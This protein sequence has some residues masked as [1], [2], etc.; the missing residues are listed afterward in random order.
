MASMTMRLPFDPARVAGPAPDPPP[1][2]PAQR[3]PLTV[4]Q[5]ADLI[6][7]AL[8]QRL[9]SPIRVIGQVSNLSAAHHWYFTLKDESA[10][11]SCI[12]WSSSARKFGFT[13]G[14][15][16]EVIAAGHVSH[17]PPQGRTQLYVSQ[18]TPVGAGAL[19]LRF[20]QMCRELRE[21]GYFEEGRKKPLP[22]FPRRIAVITSASGAALRDVVRTAS[23][24]CRAVGLVVLDVRVQGE[25]AAE[26]V[27]RAIAWADRHARRLDIDAVLVTRG[28]GSMEDL[29][30]F[31]ERA[32]AEAAYRCRLPLVAAIG[33]ESDT[34]VIE[35]VADR[36]ASTPTQAAMLLVPDAAELHKQVSHLQRRMAILLRRLVDRDGQRLRAAERYE[37]FRDPLALIRPARRRLDERE[38]SLRQALRLELARRRARLE[39]VARR[40]PTASPDVELARRRERLASLRARL[41]RAIR[42]QPER[43]RLESLTAR[44]RL[45]SRRHLRARGEQVQR[46]ERSLAAVDPHRVLHRGYSIT[47]QRDGRIIRSIREVRGGQVL[48]SQ[49][50]DGRIES[51][52]AAAPRRPPPGSDP[53]ARADQLDLFQPPK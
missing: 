36:R 39:S 45:D 6:K 5:A 43:Q 18:L 47:M 31:N 46:L 4:S 12:A 33:H 2:E 7:A 41:R 28:G 13:P 1:V 53:A 35:L 8:E 48:V 21:L 27:A 34:T 3:E 44:L 24:R 14:D 11:L 51:I 52:A 16:D 42:L 37:A 23:D 9:P 20:R 19:E 50:V 29:W 38:R 40:L 49:V 30:A 10:V 15:G 17:Y 25:G 32:V 26:Q 22:S